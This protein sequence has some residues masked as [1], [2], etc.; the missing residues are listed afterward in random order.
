MLAEERYKQIVKLVNQRGSIRVSELS[1]ICEVTE[2]T[3][4]RDLAKLEGE[5][6]LVR[7]HGG[8]V[9]LQ[10]KQGEIP[11]PKREVTNLKEKK[12][13]AEQAVSVIQPHDRI[14]L[15]AST[16][17]WYLAAA[18]P[19]IPLTVLT[20]SIKVALEL[21]EKQLI[22]VISIG[23]TLSH[24]SLSFIGPL[25][26]RSLELY[27][28]NK[29][30]ISCKG[31]HVV[32]GISD[33]NEAQALIKQKVI[34]LS[35]QVYL[36]ADYSKFDIQAFAKIADLENIYRIITDPK[37]ASAQLSEIKEQGIEVVVAR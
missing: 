37:T 19:D 4:R 1:R 11:Y 7:S 20:N 25:A 28:V 34:S 35:E 32:R 14:F 17:A 5:D 31:V 12:R 15:D 13:I 27:F 21:S 9:S 2:E 8:A 16:T 24:R 33:S 3:I 29:A 18:L 26:E 6:M 22:E 36:L 10:D 30:F 23:G